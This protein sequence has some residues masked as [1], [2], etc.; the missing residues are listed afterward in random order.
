MIGCGV[1]VS[2]SEAVF[3]WVDLPSGVLLQQAKAKVQLNDPY[4]QGDVA[5]T[6]DVIR[7]LLAERK[8]GMVAVK[9]SST[10]GK[11]P[12]SHVA[13]RLEALI[14]LAS[15]VE[16]RFVSPQAIAAFV[17]TEQPEIPGALLKYQTD[18]YVALMAVVGK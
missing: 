10:S 18:A 6:F 7:Q 4:M 15:P 9:K 13:F 5:Q 17:K 8:T 1:S 16:V 3:V 11:F 14:A 2:S 12:A